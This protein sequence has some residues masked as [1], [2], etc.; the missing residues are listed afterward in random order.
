MAL[1]K[2]IWVEQIQEVLYPSNLF[3]QYA[4]DF[5]SFCNYKTVHV[6]F[7]N[8][9]PTI[10]INPTSY[11]INAVQRTDVDFTFTI[12]GYA[13]NAF[14]VTDLEQAQISYSKMNS[15]IYN[16]VQTLQKAMGDYTASKWASTASSAITKTSGYAVTA[17][18][19]GATGSRSAITSTDLIN[20]KAQMDND[21][22]PD[23]GQRK[24]LLPVAMYYELLNDPFI[25][26]AYSYGSAVLPDGTVKNIMGFDVMKRPTVCSIT[27]GGSVNALI[28]GFS[29]G[30]ATDNLAGIAWHPQ[31]TAIAK[32]AIDLFYQANHPLYQGDVMSALALFGGTS[33]RK[34]G[35]GVY[36]ISQ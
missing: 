26:Q 23:D 12:D 28:T 5:S 25:K 6:P 16:T 21:N 3:T 9:V 22:I 32:G 8:T 35:L 36:L 10:T 7:N 31:Y 1:L 11:P 15:V 29:G 24:L 33:I 13:T 2:E 20:L 14:F 34:D 17:S 4:I 18:A 19:P 30:T 27:S